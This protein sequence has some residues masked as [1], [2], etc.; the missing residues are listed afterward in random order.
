LKKEALT[1][2][3]NSKQAE[4]MSHL[5]EIDIIEKAFAEES[6]DGIL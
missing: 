5:Y 6:T 2:I 4:Q 1:G 3:I